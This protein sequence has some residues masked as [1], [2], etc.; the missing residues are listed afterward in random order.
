MSRSERAL[1]AERTLGYAAQNIQDPRLR[2]ELL[3]EA[4]EARL[5]KGHVPRHLFKAYAAQLELADEEHEAGRWATASSAA[6]KALLLAF[7][8][9]LHVD[10]LSSPLADNPARYTAPLRESRTAIA[11][12]SPRGRKRA[13]A[14]PPG[15]RPLRLLVAHHGNDNF[16]RPVLAHYAEH[17]DVELKVLDTAADPTL[18]P[19]AKGV[20]RMIQRALGSQAAYGRRIEEALRP[21][22]DW[23]D[24]VFIDW[25]AVAAAFFTL[26][27]PGPARIV[28]RLHSYEAFS[29][30]PHI[31]DFSRVDDLVFVSEHLRDF[32]VSAIPRL[33]ERKAPRLHVIDNAVQLERFVLPKRPGARFTLGMVGVSQVAKDPGWALEVLNMLR[34]KDE[35]YTLHLIGSP[36]RPDAGPAA[37]R[38]YRTYQREL[39]RLEAAGAVRQV[40]QT[41]DVPGALTEVGVILSSSVRESWHLGLVEGA[42]SGAV[43]VVRDWP[44][45]AK[46]PHGARALFPA[47]WVVDDPAEA[48]E[49][50]LR[51][52]ATEEG[53]EKYGHEASEHAMLAWDWAHVK[54]HF[55]RL[56]LGSGPGSGR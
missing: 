14:A 7:H 51:V 10:G 2:T 15:D 9:A 11:L 40:G 27:D 21:H 30:W 3:V 56:L 23:A 26:V 29:H 46:R 24:V 8:R 19:L 17:A 47:P 12:R 13:A 16:L 5:A 55:D 33:K 43:P 42:A 38:Y 25:C 1:V 20:G 36:L 35:R 18:A 44:F 45:F 53:W 54:G 48:A 28:V 39:L 50:V 22:L 52:T 6:A 31:I 32:C 34:E 41:D 49:R 4:A 37:A